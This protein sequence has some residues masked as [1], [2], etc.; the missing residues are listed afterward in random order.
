VAVLCASPSPFPPPSVAPAPP[1]AP[2]LPFE[3]LGRTEVAGRSGVVR[4][5]LRR[6]NEVFSVSEGGNIDEHYL[7]YAIG[8]DALQ[9]D[10]LPMAA[11]QTLVIGI[12]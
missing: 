4:V 9:I 2:A 6:G 7:L 3:Y 10:Y 11:R 5:H 8:P 12:K 1:Q